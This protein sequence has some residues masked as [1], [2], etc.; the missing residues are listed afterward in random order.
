M[1]PEMCVSQTLI[2]FAPRSPKREMLARSIS[3]DW[4]GRTKHG[5]ARG[6]TSSRPEAGKD[7]RESKIFPDT[8]SRQ[9]DS[10]RSTHIETVFGIFSSSYARCSCCLGGGMQVKAGHVRHNIQRC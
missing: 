9:P 10:I 7:R 4:P 8:A 1:V 6:K 2:E 5:Q 3:K